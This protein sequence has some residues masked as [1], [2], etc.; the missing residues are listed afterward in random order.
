MTTSPRAPPAKRGERRTNLAAI[1]AAHRTLQF[2]TEVT[3]I[4]H[5]SGRSEAV[6]IN[7]R[8]D[9]SQPGNCACATY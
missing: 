5:D 8:N 1:T 9:R 2:G 6:R 3:V 7:D 4:N